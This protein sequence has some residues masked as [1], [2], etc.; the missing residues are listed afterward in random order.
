M[1]CLFSNDKRRCAFPGRDAN[2]RATGFIISEGSP[3]IGLSRKREVEQ[4]QISHL[5][6]NDISVRGYL[7]RKNVRV[8]NLRSI[9]SHVSC[10]LETLRMHHRCTG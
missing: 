7:D 10:S 8:R 2:M 5:R 4:R 3:I 1:S 6:L 9:G